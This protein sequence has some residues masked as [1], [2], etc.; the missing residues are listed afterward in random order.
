MENTAQTLT[1]RSLWRAEPEL[2][3]REVMLKVPT[4]PSSSVEAKR[5]EDFCLCWM[6]GS[7]WPSSR[8]AQIAFQV[9]LLLLSALPVQPS[10]FIPHPSLPLRKVAFPSNQVG[11]SLVVQWLRTH[12]PTAGGM[13]SISGQGTKV[14]HAAGFGQN[15]N[16]HT[17]THTHTH[18]NPPTKTL[19]NPST[20]VFH[21]LRVFFPH[22]VI[23]SL[24]G[25]GAEMNRS[26]SEGEIE[27]CPEDFLSHSRIQPEP[28]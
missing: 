27:F 17:H 7:S 20:Q 24:L 8:P 26:E 23:R 1:S 9:S 5:D 22:L 13:G 3:S 4:E 6:L 11:T 28:L 10:L 15:N 12:T 14:P 16:N 21:K 18:T 25:A 19:P 2:L